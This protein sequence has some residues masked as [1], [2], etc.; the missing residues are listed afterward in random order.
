MKEPVGGIRAQQRIRQIRRAMVLYRHH[1]R[2]TPR[3]PSRNYTSQTTLSCS[4]GAC[5]RPNTEPD[6]HENRRLDQ[7]PY[8]HPSDPNLSLR[9]RPRKRGLETGRTLW[10]ARAEEVITEERPGFPG[11]EAPRTRAS[12]SQ[13]AMVL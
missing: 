10:N 6:D 2:R 3:Q 1:I 11:F 8:R 12:V 13:D 9:H 7:A 5:L 4:L